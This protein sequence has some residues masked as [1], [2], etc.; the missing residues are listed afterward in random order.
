[1]TVPPTPPQSEH[2]SK[3]RALTITRGHLWKLKVSNKKA[4]TFPLALTFPHS[5]PDDIVKH[6]HTTARG[7]ISSSWDYSTFVLCRKPLDS[8]LRHCPLCNPNIFRLHQR[9]GTNKLILI[10]IKY[11]S[12]FCPQLLVYANQLPLLSVPSH[13]SPHIPSAQNVSRAPE[14]MGISDPYVA[15]FSFL[16]FSFFQMPLDPFPWSR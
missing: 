2:F 4:D 5:D 7:N 3:H 8:F 10:F 14:Q 9:V 12:C 6:N 11:V 16:F 15:C 1:M 13:P